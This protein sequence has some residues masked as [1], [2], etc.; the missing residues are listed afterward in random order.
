MEEFL[1]PHYNLASYEDQHGSWDKIPAKGKLVI[2]VVR[3][4]IDRFVSLYRL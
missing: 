1:M 4:P 3:N 2:S